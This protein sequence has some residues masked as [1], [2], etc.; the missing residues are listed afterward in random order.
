MRNYLL[1][2]GMPLNIITVSQ[3]GTCTITQTQGCMFIPDESAKRIIFI[4]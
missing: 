4:K 2:T 3:A 1:Q